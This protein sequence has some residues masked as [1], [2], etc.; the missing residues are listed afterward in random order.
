MK[1]GSTTGFTRSI[2]EHVLP[3]AAAQGYAPDTV[4]CSDDLP[5]GR[6]APLGMY[7]C[8]VELGG[9]SARGRAQGR[10]H[11]AGDRRG[12]GGGLRDGGGVALSGNASAGR[13][14][15]LPP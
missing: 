1:I 15:T 13:P 9:V 11:R 6:P 8:F 10:R 7:R 5:E 4:V 14:R 2:M 3:V 12:A